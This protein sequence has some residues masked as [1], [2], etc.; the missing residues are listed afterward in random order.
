MMTNTLARLRILALG[1]PLVLAGC[2]AAGMGPADRTDQ[3]TARDYALYE[4][5]LRAEGDLRTDTDPPDAPYTN[6][7]LAQNFYRIALHHEADIEKDGSEEN[8]APNR[9]GRWTED[10]RYRLIG[11]GVTPETQTEVREFARRIEGLTG[12]GFAPAEENVNFL[13]L[14]TAPDERA[15]VSGLLDEAMP[16]LGRSFDRWRRSKSLICVATNLYRDESEARIVFGMIMM[17][18]ELSPLMRSSCLQ[19]EVVQAMGLGNDHTEVRPSVFNDDE[20]FALLTRHD[21]YLLRTL[22]DRRLTVGMT[23]EEAMP[24]VRQIISELRPEGGN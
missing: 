21:E 12:L 3:P 20:E 7:D 13:I 8:S 14:I 4:A 24:V 11:S 19:E 16:A 9:L 10:I 5:M 18:T 15:R 2:A 23:A 6:D 22:Y 1:I 17:G